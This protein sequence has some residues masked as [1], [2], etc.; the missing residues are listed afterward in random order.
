MERANRDI[1]T[2]FRSSFGSR[3]FK[4][5]RNRIMFSM[6]SDSPMLYQT[7]KKTNKNVGKKRGKY[8]KHK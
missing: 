4:R 8:N 7:R 3:N 1:K 5:M 6:N 2:I